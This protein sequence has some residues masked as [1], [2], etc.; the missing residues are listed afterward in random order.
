MSTGAYSENCYEDAVIET[1]KK[2][3]WEYLHGPDIERGYRN[4]LCGE[5]L[6]YQL[7]RL[8]R[9]VPDDAVDYAFARLHEIEGGSLAARNA[10]FTEYLQGG[11]EAPC[12][13]A[14][15]GSRRLNARRVPAAARA[16]RSR[17]D[18]GPS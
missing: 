10:V 14:A 16:G 3:G 6:R 15:A 1:L 2:V 17:P 12:R 18:A 8:N 11:I 13:I 5:V 9:E 4:P 7:R